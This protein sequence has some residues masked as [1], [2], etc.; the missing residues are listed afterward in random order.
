MLDFHGL[1][2]SSIL[3]NFRKSQKLT[4]G[5]EIV[6]GNEDL[7]LPIHVDAAVAVSLTAQQSATADA[8]VAVLIG[9]GILGL[10]PHFQL[11]IRVVLAVAAD[12]A[13]G[14]IEALLGGGQTKLTLPHEQG[15]RE[16]VK[17]ILLTRGG[18]VISLHLERSL[19]D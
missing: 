17:A 2:L 13:Q 16:V 6:A 1:V 19:V 15:N 18:G 3:L 4:G 11:V 9:V 14:N 8:E 12:G 7:V 10:E 5:L